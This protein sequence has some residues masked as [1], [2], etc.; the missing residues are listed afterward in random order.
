MNRRAMIKSF[1][2]NHSKH[3]SLTEKYWKDLRMPSMIICIQGWISGSSQC[4][5]AREK[6]K[7]ERTEKEGKNPTFWWWYDCV[8]RKFLNNIESNHYTQINSITQYI[9]CKLHLYKQK[10]L[11]I[12][13][14]GSIYNGS[15]KLLRLRNKSN[16]NIYKLLSVYKN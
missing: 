14:K 5:K 10:Q 15:E 7:S 6:K 8:S 3:H 11:E 4:N 13:I 12:E 16:K 1:Y 2:K 9:I